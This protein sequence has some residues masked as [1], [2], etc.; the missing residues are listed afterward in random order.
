MSRPRCCSTI[1]LMPETWL[2]TESPLDADTTR[3]GIRTP[4]AN[5]HPRM[6]GVEHSGSGPRRTAWVASCAFNSVSGNVT[7]GVYMPATRTIYE[8]L[9]AWAARALHHSDVSV[10]Q[11]SIRWPRRNIT[12]ARIQFEFVQPADL[13]VWVGVAG[14]AEVPWRALRSR[15]VRLIY[16]NSEPLSDCPHR[17]VSFLRPTFTG[18][19]QQCVIK[20]TG[21]VID[22][23]MVDELWDY[24]VHNL[25]LCNRTRASIPQMR[26][27]PPGLVPDS[28][29][30]TQRQR[31]PPKL[32]FLGSVGSNSSAGS[33]RNACW[34]RLKA[35]LGENLVHR[36]D[37]WSDI[38]FGKLLRDDDYIF[39]NIHRRCGGGGVPL[40]A[41]RLQLLL[42][43]AQLVVSERAQ[44]KDE[45]RYHDVISFAT[46]QNIPA[47]YQLMAN[48]SLDQRNALASRRYST[49]SRWFTPDHL[50]REAGA[51]GMLHAFFFK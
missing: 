19:G 49:Y 2:E 35:A 20:S 22:G 21:C 12:A 44:I 48:M 6:G 40:E 23:S 38:A 45:E 13:L 11:I 32:L 14:Y 3:A 10:R 47:T 36:F 15:S 24:S 33:S 9:R 31:E 50:F 5:G 27:I 7:A 8:G 16:Y 28:P 18:D 26:L 29:R 51:F 25:N 17:R 4:A 46:L 39:L 1:A 37:I 41:F 43:A 42:S 30:P 34:T